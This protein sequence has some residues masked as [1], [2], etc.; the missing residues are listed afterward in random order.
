MQNV[1]LNGGS[2]PPLST[3]DTDVIHVI[4]Y[5]RPSLSVF[6]YIQQVIKN[7][8]VGRPGN[9]AMQDIHTYIP[10]DAPLLLD[11]CT[12]HQVPLL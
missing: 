8:M 5:T 3:V 7:W 10:Y 11:K 9:E 1:F 6:A 2:L 12:P 4:K